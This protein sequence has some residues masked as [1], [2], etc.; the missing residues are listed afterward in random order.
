MTDDDTGGAAAG[1]AAGVAE[2][3]TVIVAGVRAGRDAESVRGRTVA[4]AE[5]TGGNVAGMATAAGA[6]PLRAEPFA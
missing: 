1:T 2:G 5:G 3:A 6:S 4:G